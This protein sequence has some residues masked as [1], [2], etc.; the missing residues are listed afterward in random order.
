[1]AQ[2]MFIKPYKLLLDSLSVKARCL[3]S[4]DLVIVSKTYCLNLN[5]LYKSTEIYYTNDVAVKIGINLD[6][7]THS[8]TFSCSVYLVTVNYATRQE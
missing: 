6:S 3:E 4:N 8:L 5:I 7:F 1:M 2:S